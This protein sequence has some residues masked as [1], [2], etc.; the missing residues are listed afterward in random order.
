MKKR[1]LFIMFAIVMCMVFLHIP[2]FAMES[3]IEDDTA[4]KVEAV[5]KSIYSTDTTS[6]IAVADNGQIQKE[7]AIN[8]MHSEIET[9]ISNRGLNDFYAGSYFDGEKLIVQFTR[10]TNQ[11]NYLFG[12]IDGDVIIKAVNFS[13]GYLENCY[14]SLCSIVDTIESSGISAFYVDEKRNAVIIT[15]LECK[16]AVVSIIKQNATN[17]DCI[18]FELCEKPVRTYVEGWRPGRGIY[19]Y[20]LVNNSYLSYVGGYSTGY[21]A[22]KGSKPGFVTSAHG[23][24]YGDLVFYSGLTQSSEITT[25]YVGMITARELSQYV[26]AAFVQLDTSKYEQSSLVYWT[27]SQ[28]GVTRPGTIMDAE[29]VSV[30]SITTSTTIYKSGMSTY[31]TTGTLISSGVSVHF[32]DLNLTISGLIMTNITA[33]RGDSGAISYVIRG[34]NYRGKTLGIVEGGNGT[35]TF[36]VPATTINSRLGLTIN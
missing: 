7:N 26:D 33:D 2:T 34:T 14:E 9:S 25:K 18:V 23:N 22:S 5:Y 17:A 36:L 20:T 29:V 27:S 12:E 11:V 19:M 8:N 31:L 4:F 1:F 21:M 35:Y 24:N 3:N 13:L 16:D 10:I 15:M 32:A 30:S 28:P 6:A